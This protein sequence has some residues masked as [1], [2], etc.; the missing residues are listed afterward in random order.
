MWIENIFILLQLNVYSS[1][2]PKSVIL[3]IDKLHSAIKGT[4]PLPNSSQIE[5]LSS[6]SIAIQF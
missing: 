1:W 3:V 6:A 4:S 2:I 5:T